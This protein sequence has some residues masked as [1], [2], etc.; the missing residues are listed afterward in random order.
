[1]LRTLIA[2]LF[3]AS[4]VAAIPISVPAMGSAVELS[5]SYADGGL[6]WGY[7][8]LVYRG[9]ISERFIDEVPVV[10][11][12]L[13]VKV[14]ATGTLSGVSRLPMVGPDWGSGPGSYVDGHTSHGLACVIVNG[15]YIDTPQLAL[16]IASGRHFVWGAYWGDAFDVTI[17]DDSYELA[18]SMPEPGAAVLM[19]I[20]LGLLSRV[21]GKP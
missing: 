15:C 5:G 16:H 17:G 1:M 6:T 19:L 8:A 2:V 11:T 12:F 13:V 10:G 18:A 14:G 20:G 9:R 7:D 4:P 21:R 3:L